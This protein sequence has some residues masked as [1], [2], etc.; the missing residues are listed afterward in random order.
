[1][2]EDDRVIEQALVRHGQ[3]TALAAD[4]DIE[5]PA[6]DLQEVRQGAGRIIAAAP[7][8]E[9]CHVDRAPRGRLV[10]ALAGD[11]AG[12][13]ELFF[14]LAIGR[15]GQYVGADR[16]AGRDLLLNFGG[17]LLAVLRVAQLPIAR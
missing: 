16:M 14:Q 11:D 2:H 17:K 8:Q 1:M 5:L 15:I 12:H 4:A 3:Q 10:D 9:L 6:D 7:M 13:I